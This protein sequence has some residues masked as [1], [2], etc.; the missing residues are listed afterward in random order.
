MT[1]FLYKSLSI[2]VYSLLQGKETNAHGNIGHHGLS[3]LSQ[4][5]IQRVALFQYH[6]KFNTINTKNHNDAKS[7]DTFT[8]FQTSQL[9]SIIFILSTH[10]FITFY[11]FK[12][13]HFHRSFKTKILPEFPSNIWSNLVCINTP[14]I[15]YLHFT[16]FRRKQ[17][18]KSSLILG[19]V[20][21]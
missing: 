6:P 15:T 10:Y 11:Q 21:S 7:Q 4:E 17:Y 20:I 12:I 13:N 8:Q 19:P 18:R 14:I 2:P 16:D 3:S 9:I 5:I 1:N